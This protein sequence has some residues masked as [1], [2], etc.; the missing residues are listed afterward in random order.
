M[1]KFCAENP[2]WCKEQSERL[3]ARNAEIRAEKEGEL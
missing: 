1:K 3:T 2:D